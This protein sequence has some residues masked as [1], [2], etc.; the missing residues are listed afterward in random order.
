[1]WDVLTNP[2]QVKLWPYGSSLITNWETGSDIK[3]SVEWDGKLFE[4]RGKVLVF[5]PNELVKYSLIVS[6]SSFKTE[7]ILDIN[8]A[9]YLVIICGYRKTG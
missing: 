1:M 8:F 7:M 3:F 9:I 6:V 5:K 2:A 4:Q